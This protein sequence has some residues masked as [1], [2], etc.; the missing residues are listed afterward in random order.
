MFLRSPNKLAFFNGPPVAGNPVRRDGER[1]LNTILYPIQ[2]G[3]FQ[4]FF[5][6]RYFWNDA[7]GFKCNR[8]Y[9][10]TS[11]DLIRVSLCTCT[12]NIIQIYAHSTM[13]NNI[14][15]SICYFFVFRGM[16]DEYT[17]FFGDCKFW[18]FLTERCQNNTE[19]MNGNTLGQPKK[20]NK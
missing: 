19:M 4:Y 12:K 14:Y 3:I 1:R 9:D 18:H 6:L 16:A 20:N 7:N 11:P 17:F 10:S 5:D 13:Q 8:I 15:K 2:T